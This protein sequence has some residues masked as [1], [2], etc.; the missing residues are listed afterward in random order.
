[1]DKLLKAEELAAQLNVSTATIRRLS[2]AGK[3]PFIQIGKSKRYSLEQVKA[4]SAFTPTTEE[5]SNE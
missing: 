4:V 5:Q 2:Q 3:I 1:M